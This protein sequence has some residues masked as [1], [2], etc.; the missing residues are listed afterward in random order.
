MVGDYS[1]EFL[2]NW[3]LVPIG[4]FFGWLTMR[5]RGKRLVMK[6]YLIPIVAAMLVL[7]S[8]LLMSCSKSTIT[9]T[10]PSASPILTQD[11]QSYDNKSLG[12]AFRYPKTYELGVDDPFSAGIQLNGENI[13]LA[14]IANPLSRQSVDML[15]RDLSH[16]DFRET[17]R[18]DIQKKSW[19]GLRLQGEAAKWGEQF[20]EVIYIVKAPSN[21]VLTLLAFS[22]ERNGDFAE[23]DAIWDS[24]VLGLDSFAMPAFLLGETP[25]ATLRPEDQGYS[26]RYP[27]GW[28]PVVS[29]G[30]VFIQDPDDPD[31][32]VMSILKIQPTEANVDKATEHAL[33]ALVVFDDVVLLSQHE[34]SLSGAQDAVMLVGSAKF[35][36][37]SP[38]VFRTLLVL[39]KDNTYKLEVVADAANW[40]SLS[41]IFDEIFKSFT[42][43]SAP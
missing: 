8:G 29:R 27:Y 4:V 28:S 31:T 42:I 21:S 39:T 17:G 11:W 15:A 18:I 32:F 13:Y 30:L 37:G 41:P 40:E 2:L 38:A 12:L 36:D 5:L 24:L 35:T 23:V 9:P 7:N 14:I 26:L 1:V 3:L 43:E 6:R 34:V 33:N 10:M 22:S 20:D 16:T 25:M 19:N